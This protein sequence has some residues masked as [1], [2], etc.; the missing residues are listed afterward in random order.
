M[1]GPMTTQT[2]Q[3][4]IGKEPHHWRGDRD[5]L[6]QFSGAFMGLQG[7]DTTL[8]PAEMQEF[9]DFLATLHLPPNPFRGLDNSLPTNMPLP[10]HFTTGRFAAAGQPLPNG[11]AQRGLAIFRPPR[12]LDANFFACVTCH[13]LP[14]GLGADARF[15]GG[16]FQPIPLGPNGERHHGL[17]SV[18]GTSNVTMKIPQLRTL[19]KKVGFDATQIS[20]NRGFGL[21]HD[22]SVDSIARF[23]GEPVF[24][25]QSDQEVADLVAL[26]LAFSGSGLPAGS[27][28]NVL[29]PPG[30][31]SQDTHAAVGKQTTLAGPP[32]AAQTD[33][34]A[35]VTALADAGRVG[36]VVK[37]SQAGLA[38]GYTYVGNGTFQSDRAGETVSG[39]LL[40][41]SAS[42]GGELTY[43]VVPKPAER[44]IGIDQDDD[45][46]LD[47]DELDAGFDPA[48]PESHPAVDR[49]PVA[50]DDAASTNE[51]VAVTVNV[52]ANDSDPDGDPLTVSSVTQGA[53]GAATNDGNGQ[54]TYRPNA[55]LAGADSF[56]YTVSDGRGAAATATVRVTIVATRLHVSD[57]DGSRA[58]T[59]GKLW[60]ATVEITVVDT[61]G[62][63]VSGATVTGSWSAG[64]SG[65]SS[66][67]TNA[68]GIATVQ[69]TGLSR[70][71]TAS[72]TF[73]VTEIA[74]A[75]LSY[76]AAQNGD[77]DG[78]SNGTTIVVRRP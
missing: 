76:N 21:L 42:P 54:V 71:N 13:T 55:G 64:A 27:A 68:S 8:T 11:N 43:T 29:E 56:T 16:M 17:V 25:V 52:I 78:D 57:L 22:G 24:T 47:R 61:A 48:D 32:S 45:T 3:D 31:A 38:R 18:D 41:Q 12:L 4:I 30:T 63:P 1:K 50:A 58:N 35:R 77:P 62:K 10:G 49:P 65:T 14:A 26:M 15:S 37:G 36:L 75:T 59:S 69:K 6:E 33:F 66:A 67:V 70:R 60:S 53:L 2:L 7:D 19:Y 34:I 9:E 23:V 44:R 46:F 39:A 40:A 5:G 73:T 74:H 72:V 51:G 20:N 28:T